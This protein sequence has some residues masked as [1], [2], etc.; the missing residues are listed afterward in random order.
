MPDYKEMYLVLFRETTKAITALQNAQQTTE[1]M[2]IV[3]GGNENLNA[4]NSSDRADEENHP[5]QS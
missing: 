2:Y 3:D 5:P 1:E 4:A